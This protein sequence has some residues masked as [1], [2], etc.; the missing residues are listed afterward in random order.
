MGTRVMA[1]SEIAGTKNEGAVRMK[2]LQGWRATAQEAHN[3][4]PWCE[5]A[6]SGLLLRCTE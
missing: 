1:D 3:G 6:P 4:A 5:V 2:E